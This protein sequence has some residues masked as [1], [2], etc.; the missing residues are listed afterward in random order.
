M[1]SGNMDN[2]RMMSSS[3]IIKRWTNNSEMVLKCQHSANHEHYSLLVYQLISFNPDLHKKRLFEESEKEKRQ[4]HVHRKCR[5][6]E[7]HREEDD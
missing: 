4:G 5:S 1:K 2:I 3:F 6:M 7:E